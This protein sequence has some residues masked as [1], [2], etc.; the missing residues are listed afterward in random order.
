[1]GW[2][3]DRASEMGAALA[4][5]VLFSMAPLLVLTIAVVSAVYGPD[6]ARERVVAEVEHR[7][8]RQTAD[9]VRTVLDNV[10]SGTNLTGVSA[11]GLA[12]LL[13]GASGMFTSLRSSLQRIWRFPST[14]D[15]FVWGLVKTYVIALLMVLVACVFVLVLVAVST[16][17]PLVTRQLYDTMPGLAS[18]GP[19]IDLGVSTLLLTLMFTF[20]FRIL[21]DRRLSYPQVLSGAFVSAALFAV[22]KIALGYYFAT[23]AV[24]SAYGAAG[25]LVVFLAWV[26]Y[27]SQIVFY[28][29]EVIRFGLPQGPS[30]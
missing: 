21:S 4:Y 12:T 6:Q 23:V 29:A 24:G 10:K 13:F 5:Y 25:S 18:A 8:D 26:Y 30:A 20:T 27:S 16:A 3:E 28:G 17:M 2:G 9:A 22:G 15:S 11:I 7:I 14:Q 19:W 1:V